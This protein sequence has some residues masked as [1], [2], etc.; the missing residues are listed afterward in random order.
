LLEQL[1]EKPDYEWRMID[2]SHIKMHL[3]VAGTKGGNPAMNRTKGGLA[4]SDI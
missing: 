2:A 4:R 1:T 3:H